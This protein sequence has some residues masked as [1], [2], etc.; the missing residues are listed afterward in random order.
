M[1]IPR[2]RRAL[3]VP[4]Q[5]G[6][7]LVVEAA[8]LDIGAIGKELRN[9]GDDGLKDLLG[10]LLHPARLRVRKRLLPPCLGEGLQVGVVEHRLHGRGPLVDSQE[11]AH[12]NL[13][14]SAVRRHQGP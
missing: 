1:A 3:R 9:G 5:H 6:L 11:H 10:I 2:I 14:Y 13:L 12:I 7:S 4:R 8:R